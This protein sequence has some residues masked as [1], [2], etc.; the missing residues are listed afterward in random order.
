MT[1]IELD[2]HIVADDDRA[3]PLSETGESFGIR[4]RTTLLKRIRTEPG[5]P[6]PWYVNGRGFC[7]SSQILAHL[8]RLSANRS[9][10]GVTHQ[11]TAHARAG[12]A[13]NRSEHAQSML[14]GEQ[15]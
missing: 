6:Q 12:K 7:L 5:F 13:R 9:A 2:N 1:A 8:E 15:P 10:S 4:S 14:A 11:A 3:V